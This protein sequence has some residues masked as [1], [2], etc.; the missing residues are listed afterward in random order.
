[1]NAK[2][3]GTKNLQT[4]WLKVFWFILRGNDFLVGIRFSWLRK[5]EILLFSVG[6][7]QKPTTFKRNMWD[8]CLIIINEYLHVI[9]IF[10]DKYMTEKTGDFIHDYA[11]SLKYKFLY[12]SSEVFYRSRWFLPKYV[13]NEVCN[14]ATALYSTIFVIFQTLWRDISLILVKK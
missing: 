3:C 9:I 10:K 1:M 6:F 13:E 8:V 7:K 2:K 12:A 11:I 5:S 14:T 4:K